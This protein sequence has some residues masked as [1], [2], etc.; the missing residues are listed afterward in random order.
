MVEKTGHWEIDCLELPKANGRLVLPLI[1]TPKKP[2][3]SSGT[4]ASQKPEVVL[5]SAVN[6]HEGPWSSCLGSQQ[7]SLCQFLN[8]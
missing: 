8:Q 6:D 5:S 4:T 3:G 1:L 7:V 2:M